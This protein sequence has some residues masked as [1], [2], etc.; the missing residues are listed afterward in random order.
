MYLKVNITTSAKKELISK[1][2][3]DYFDIS[4]KEKAE[5]N[6]ANIRMLEILAEHFKIPK[7]KIRIIKGHHRRH[8]L[9]LI[10]ES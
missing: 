7:N 6:K 1:K 4:V 5:E 3:P 9:L 2:S 8:K 10:A